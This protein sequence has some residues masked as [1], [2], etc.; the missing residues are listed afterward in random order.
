MREEE[1]LLPLILHVNWTD[2][3]SM[4]APVAAD[5][6]PVIL[7]NSSVALLGGK[8]GTLS[9][10]MPSWWLCWVVVKF[11]LYKIHRPGS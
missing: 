6:S 4:L 1:P 9:P 10:E 8:L 7:E 2:L 3:L 11:L 5:P